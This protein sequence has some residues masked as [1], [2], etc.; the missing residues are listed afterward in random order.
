MGKQVLGYVQGTKRKV[1]VIDIANE[2]IGDTIWVELAD[3]LN[4]SVGDLFSEEHPNKTNIG[5]TKDF[6][7]DDWLKLINKNPELLQNPIAVNGERAMLITRRSEILEFFGVDSAGLE[8]K[9]AN[10][11]PT[12]SST[13][14]DEDFI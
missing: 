8:K 2:T 5:N 6:S 4:L 7:T 14:E 13:T 3:N 9:M 12:T 10:E 11:P 1:Q